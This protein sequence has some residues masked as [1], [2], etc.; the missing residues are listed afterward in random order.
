MLRGGERGAR[1][2][3]LARR[4]DARR[5]VAAGSACSD[6]SVS[7]LKLKMPGVALCDLVQKRCDVP[8]TAIA[9]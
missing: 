2:R 3:D 6:T 9:M 4:C 8:E 5:T 7:S 1:V